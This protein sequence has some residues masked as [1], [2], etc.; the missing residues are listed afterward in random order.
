MS[1]IKML[2]AGTGWKMEMK[3]KSFRKFWHNEAVGNVVPRSLLAYT[4]LMITGD[5][6]SL[7]TAQKI[8]N[9]FLQ[10]QF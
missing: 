5:R 2:P 4:D 1:L 8:Y 10:H 3:K 9:E 6:R 7:E